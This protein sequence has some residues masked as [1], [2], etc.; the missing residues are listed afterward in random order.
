VFFV[1]FSTDAPVYYRPW[2]TLGLITVNTLVFILWNQGGFGDPEVVLRGYGLTHGAGIHPLQWITSN[3]LHANLLHLVSN[4]FFL[5]AFG[6]VVEGKVGPGAFLGIFSTIAIGECAAEQICLSWMAPGLSFGA[7]SAIFGLMAIAMIWAPKNE[8]TVFYWILMRT[9]IADISIQ[10]FAVMLLVFNVLM[11]MFL[12][13]Q[14]SS[15]LLH[16]VG[17]GIGAFLGWLYVKRKWVDCENWDLFSVM[18]GKNVR[19]IDGEIVERKCRERLTRDGKPV[20]KKRK[21]APIEKKVKHL[22]RLRSLLA[23]GKPKAA[24]DEWSTARHFATEWGAFETDLINLA[25][26]LQ[27]ADYIVESL[28]VHHHFIE[29][30]PDRADRMR[31]EAAELVF[32][33]QKRPHATVRLVEGLDATKLPPD[34]AKRLKALRQNAGA[35][36]DSGHIEIEGTPSL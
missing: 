25:G 9:G 8:L 21:V 12:R 35:L 18:A 23:E 22:E 32:K 28:E 15:E 3:F 2:G 13:F 27:A 5:W 34:L 14:V 11:A 17:G 20:K 6:L 19:S 4:M 33:H 1:P 36:I 31:I 30:F 7:S 16:L 26:Q 24:Y 29:Q 10:T